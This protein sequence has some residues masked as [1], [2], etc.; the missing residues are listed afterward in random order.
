MVSIRYN[1][2]MEN[3]YYTYAYLRLDG[4]PYYIGRGKDRRAFQQ[5]GH[6]VK[7]PPRDR[8]LMLKTEI[9]FEESIKHEIYMIAVFGRKNNNTGIL[10]NYTD[11]GEGCK[12]IVFSEESLA[13]MSRSRT[14]K[15]ASQS[16]RASISAGLKKAW[17]EGRHHDMTGVNNPNSEGHQG[18]KNGRSKIS[19]NDRR[20]IAKEYIPGKKHG[21]NGNCSELAHR[22]GLSMGLIRRIAKDPRWIS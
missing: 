19:D 6:F 1:T 5:S 22:F 8:I 2:T 21:H 20:T 16:H 13:K 12:G 9:S 15:K 4:T 10:R 7:V 11:G 17:S 14:G 3:I 18:E